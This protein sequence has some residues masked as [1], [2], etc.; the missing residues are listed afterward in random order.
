MLALAL[1][2]A[3]Q[4]TREHR[5]ADMLQAAFLPDIPDHL[6]GLDLA[7]AYSPGLRKPRSAGTCMMRSPCP[8]AAW[9]W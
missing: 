5:V 8:M 3:R 7:K 6:L 1:D 4:Y 9:P 2:N